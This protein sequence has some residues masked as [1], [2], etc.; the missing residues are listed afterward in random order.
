MQ[1][2]IIAICGATAS[3]KTSLAIALAQKINSEI[4]SFDSRQCYNELNIGVAKPTSNEL[5]QVQ[6]HFI[7]SHSIFNTVNA[8]VYEQYAL[9]KLEQ[10]FTLHNTVVMVGGTGLYL[11]ALCNGVDAI[12]QI[13]EALRLQLQ[14]EYNTQGIH[15][16]QSEIKKYDNSYTQANDLNNAQRM[17][18][19]LEVVL[20]TGNTIKHYHNQPKPLRTFIVEKYAI[21]LE[22]ELLYQRINSRVDSMINQGLEQEAKSF[23][24]QKDLNALQT[25][26]YSEWW[27]YFEG[28]TNL[29]STI[30]AIKQHTR[31]YAKRQITWF[32]RDASLKWIS[33][34]KDIN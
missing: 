19:A 31:N 14:N 16:L 7:N 20:H 30:D 13:P 32:K 12:P 11:N 17:L 25:V 4:L 27:Q 15:W 8:A 5:L 24:Q 21:N 34:L 23:I 6:H 26:G 1:K 3:G 29:Q 22:R 2:K 33:S 10:L 9:Q 18:R 28:K